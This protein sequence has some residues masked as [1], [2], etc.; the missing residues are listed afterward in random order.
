MLMHAFN[1][2]S[3]QNYARI[4]RSVQGELTTSV[5]NNQKIGQ[6]EDMAIQLGIGNYRENF[7][8]LALISFIRT[9]TK[10]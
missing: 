7:S 5:S 9:R 6:E 2:P 3:Q 8:K 10:H 4:R 1:H